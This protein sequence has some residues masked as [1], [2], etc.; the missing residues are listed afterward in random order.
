MNLSP[1]QP[2]ECIV[3]SKPLT[4]SNKSG[5]CGA[6]FNKYRSTPKDMVD[7]INKIKSNR[8]ELVLDGKNINTY[9]GYR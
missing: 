2:H 5:I 6:C 4:K 8:S 3:C 1:I 9:G 7:L